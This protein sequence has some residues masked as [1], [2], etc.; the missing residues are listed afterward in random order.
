MEVDTADQ[1]ERDYP[2]R[3]LDNT[4]PN[5]IDIMKNITP[6]LIPYHIRHALEMSVNQYTTPGTNSAAGP[7]SS[8]IILQAFSGDTW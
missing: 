1:D 7:T 2:E 4:V 3:S 6:T 8:S 5:I